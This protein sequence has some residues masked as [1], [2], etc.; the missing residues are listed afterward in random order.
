MAKRPIITPKTYDPTT[1]S[2]IFHD[3]ENRLISLESP[4]KTYDVT[5]AGAA[6]RSLDVTTATLSDVKDFLATLIKDLQAA[7]KIG[8]S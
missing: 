3:L 5:N 2:N 6:V 1:F 8:K 7:G 4:V